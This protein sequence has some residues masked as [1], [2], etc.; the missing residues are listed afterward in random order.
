VLLGIARVVEPRHIAIGG[1]M[2]TK[3]SKPA[4][5]NLPEKKVD[6]K[7]AAAVKGG[8]TRLGKLASNHNQSL[9]STASR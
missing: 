1:L 2:S 7:D 8:A 9:R 3:K 5:T 4:V 6:T